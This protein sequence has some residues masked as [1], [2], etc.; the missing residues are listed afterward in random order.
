MNKQISTIAKT[1]ADG[2]IEYSAGDISKAEKILYDLQNILS[3][4]NS[5]EELR[6]LLKNPA[7]DFGKKIEIINE[8]FK[9]E[10]DEQEKNILKMLIEKQRFNEFENIIEALKSQIQ[11]FKGEKEIFITSAVTLDDDEKFRI[12]SK[13]EA[14]FQ[15]KILPVWKEDKEILGGL[16]IQAD[17]DVI[18]MSLL[19]KITNLSKNIIK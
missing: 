8:I 18:D 10:L 14:K 16:I 1:Y 2:I 19:N 17:D 6:E 7:I 13:L 9:S 12:I 3:S 4:L 11:R 5:S 15:S